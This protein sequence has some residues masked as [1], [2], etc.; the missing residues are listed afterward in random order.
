MT[1]KFVG[2]FDFT[3]YHFYLHYN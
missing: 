2:W 3:T 1:V